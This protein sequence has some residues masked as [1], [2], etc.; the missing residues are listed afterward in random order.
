MGKIEKYDFLY[1][2]ILVVYGVY[3]DDDSSV[4]SEWNMGRNWQDKGI[5]REGKN[6]LSGKLRVCLW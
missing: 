4:W 2:F 6:G 1:G 5:I 3:G